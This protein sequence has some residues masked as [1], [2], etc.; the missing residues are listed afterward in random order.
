MDR[1][2]IKNIVEKNGGG[3]MPLGGNTETLG[4]H[5]GYGFGMLAEIFSSIL[6][7]GGTSND[8]MQGGRGGICHG[9]AAIDPKIFGDADAIK[10]H[11]SA[12]LAQ[13]RESPKAQGRT[14]IYTH[15]EK[16]VEAT[17]DRIKNGIPVNDNTMVELME[18][19]EYLG[20]DFSDY[21]KGYSPPKADHF[22]DNY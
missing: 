3:I 15:G 17:A 19:C 14:R 4:G 16:E 13:L 12:Y 20:M 22:G 2:K 5:K 10:R 1:N 9:F 18:L 8:C 7:L 11:F 21:F 6:S